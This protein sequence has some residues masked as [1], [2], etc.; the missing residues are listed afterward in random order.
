[1]DI[2]PATAGDVTAAP[3]W[4]AGI[5][6][7]ADRWRDDATRA[8]VGTEDGMVVAAG[9]LFTSPVRDDRYWVEVVV[10]PQRR[11]RG[12]GRS[13][14]RYLADLRTDPK[15]MCSRGFVSSAAVQFARG[16]G[17]HAYQTCPPERVQTVDA[18]RLTRS[19]VATV[20]GTAVDLSELQRAW[21][22]IYEWMH[23]D[24]AP[25]APGF[26]E[27]LL[28][29]FADELDLV[30]TRVVGEGRVRAA[31][32]VFADAP[33]PVVVAECRERDETDGLA[34]LRACVR[35][36][37]LSLAEDGIAAISFDGHDT[38]PHF[39]PLLD[40]LPVSGEAFELLEWG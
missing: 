28:E 24:W 11:R 36:S 23:A 7:R 38:D 34:L 3:D 40:E 13:I 32:F 4:L 30:H 9:H 29:D 5:D 21:T 20:A 15:P 33:E 22:D 35:D 26:E 1:M 16:L 8:V 31:A 14:A 10:A 19:P 27:P 39:R 2:R 17:A 6:L 18:A 25:V 37:L 12:H